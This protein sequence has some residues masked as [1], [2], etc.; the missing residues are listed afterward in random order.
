[1]K[2]FI[3]NFFKG[4][5]IGIANIIPGVSGGTIAVVLGIF[6]R[7]LEAVNG[8][9][10]DFKK[11]FLFLLAVFAGAGFGIVLLSSAIEYSL[12]N[13]SFPTS[14]F[15]VGL[16]VGSI[17]LIYSKT[18]AKSIKPA[19]ILA[20]LIAF[21]AV[22]LLSSGNNTEVIADFRPE[23]SMYIMLLF[24]GIIASAAMVIPGISGSFILML[25]GLYP[26][27]I[28]SIAQIKS[29]LLNPKD[30]AKLLEIAG[31]LIPL[32]I[33]VIIGIIIVT[34]LIRI[35]LDKYQTQTYFAILGLIL[36]SV[37]GI[38]NSPITYKCGLD[39]MPMIAGA[40]A[41]GVG[42]IISLAFGKSE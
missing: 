28:H 7:L 15:F 29:Y 36:G 31:V 6:E 13:Y 2:L 14:M 34:K 41:C 5:F 9:F 18:N 42:F 20:T 16:V 30:M 38:F 40:L 26:M 11:H 24:S 1:M 23:P 35:F 25:L 3:I 37:Y 27:V 32:G 19:N 21:G 12:N 8:I 22:V 10:K 4:I 17:P 33:G 39:T